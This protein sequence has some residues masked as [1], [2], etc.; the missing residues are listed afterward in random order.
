MRFHRLS[1]LLVALAVTA[2][3]CSGDD[4][5]DSS[6]PQAV[7]AAAPGKTIAEG[8][9]R[10]AID[11]SLS[12][13]PARRSV[14]GEGAFDFKGERGRLDL[15][16]GPLLPSAGRAEIVFSEDVVYLKVALGLPQLKKRPWLKIDLDEL[17]KAGVG[18]IEALR[19]LRTNDPKAALNYLRGATGDVTREGE[20][21]VRGVSTTRYRATVDLE[22]AKRAVDEEL[23]GDLDQVR[24]QLGTNRLPVQAWIDGEGRLRRLRY[25]VDVSTLDKSAPARAAGTGEVSAAFELFDFGVGVDV[26]PPPADQTI[27]LQELLG[28]AAR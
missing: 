8:T 20:E 3:A 1:V 12:G 18:D 10:V 26:A 11:V 21:V 28:G 6:S 27:T 7:L 25:T 23:R 15:D 14:T 5:V 19:Q 24:K 9:S 17:E 22:K 16:L 2:G 13:E 4:E